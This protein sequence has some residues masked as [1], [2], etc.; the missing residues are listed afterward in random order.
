MKLPLLAVLSALALSACGGGVDPNINNIAT[1]KLTISG[2]KTFTTGCTAV[3]AHDDSTG[4]TGFAISSNDTT[5]GAFNF[6]LEVGSGDL[7]A[8]TYTKANTANGG[9]TYSTPDYSQSWAALY[10]QSGSTDQGSFSLALTSTGIKITASGGAGWTNP[11]GSADF[12]LAP[13]DGGA[14]GNIT[15]HVTF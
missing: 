1:C 8:T 15:V 4:K 7:S 3:G 12:T 13:L 14:T 9:A 2:A 10:N 11:K 5:N 6:A